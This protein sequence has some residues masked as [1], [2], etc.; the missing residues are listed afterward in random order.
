MNTPHKHR[1]VIIAW[2][3]GETIET[4]CDNNRWK[5]ESH[6]LWYPTVKY[7]VKPNIHNQVEKTVRR[8]VNNTVGDLLVDDLMSKFDISVKE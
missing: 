1:D 6:P 3:N 8:Y 4:L 2:A 5:V 7:R